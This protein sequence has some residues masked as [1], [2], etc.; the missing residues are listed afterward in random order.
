MESFRESALTRL[1]FADFAAVRRALIGVLSALLLGGSS[2]FVSGSLLDLSFNPT[3]ALHPGYYSAVEFVGLQSATNIVILETYM[4]APSTFVAKVSRLKPQGLLDSSFHAGLVTDS[5][6]ERGEVRSV[7]LQPDGGIIVAG[8]FT[9]FDGVDR[10]NIV[11][12]NADGTLDT[13]FA[14]G[15][16]ILSAEIYNTASQSDGRVLIAGAALQVGGVAKPAGLVRLNPDGTLD[17]SFNPAVNGNIFCLAVQGDGRILVGGEFASVDGTNRLVIARLNGDG[18]LDP[19]FEFVNAAAGARAWQIALQGDGWILLSGQAVGSTNY[20]ETRQLVRL[21]TDGS[22]D[23][24]FDT[25]ASS[26]IIVSQPDGKVLLSGAF[27]AIDGMSRNGVARLMADGTLDLG[28]DPGTGFNASGIGVGAL[29]LQSDGKVL[30]G[31]GFT[32]FDGGPCPTLV[33]LNPGYPSNASILNISNYYG[34]AVSVDEDATNV[35]LTVIRAGNTS[36]NVTVRYRTVDGTAISGTNYLAQS[37]LITFAPGVRTQTIS[38][39]VLDDHQVSGDKT[40]QVYLT[41]ITGGALLGQSSNVAVTVADVDLGLEFAQTNYFADVLQTSVTIPLQV[42]GTHLGP[43]PHSH[44]PISIEISTRDG[45]ARAGRDYDPADGVISNSFFDITLHDDTSAYGDHTVLLTLR[46]PSSNVVLGPLTTAVLT[47]RNDNTA[48]GV[49]VGLNGPI[50]AIA[51]QPDGKVVI[52]GEFTLVDGKSRNHLARLNSDTVLDPTFDPGTGTD[53]NVQALGLQSDGKIIIGGAFTNL[54][55]VYR[56]RIAR[57]NPDGSVDAGFDPGLGWSGGPIWAWANA[58]VTA[59]A[60]QPDGKILTSSLLTNFNGTPRPGLARLNPNG[61][62]DN[63]FAPGLT[64]FGLRAMAALTNGQVVVAGFFPLPA[65]PSH[66]SLAVLNADGSMDTNRAIPSS[67]FSSVFTEIGSLAV[68]PDGDI[69]VTSTASYTGYLPLLKLK[70]DGAV[71]PGFPPQ[72]INGGAGNMTLQSDG[73]IL[74]ASN[75][76]GFLMFYGGLYYTL[77]R[78]NA[79]GS[80]DSG[81]RG[82]RYYSQGT[83]DKTAV[84]PDGS[85]L[86]F[87][88]FTEGNTRLPYYVRRLNPDG[89]DVQDLHFLP[90]VRLPNGQLH[91]ALRGQWAKPYVLQV[92]EYLTNWTTV[93]TNDRPH[94]PIGFI[95]YDAPDFGRRFY[96]VH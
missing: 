86:A 39:P 54:D 22:L 76:A 80:I 53:G 27:A 67:E 94:V 79:D 52:G 78:L 32:S 28:F 26:S 14:T 70:P 90:P 2:A 59:L 12:L 1:A 5:P 85:I 42:M 74:L 47:I 13:N 88:T 29:A 6:A 36:S 57:V 37:G 62:L 7:S 93:A 96:R 45:T 49:E 82:L 35:T 66:A 81:F 10:T 84:L 68:Q 19:T 46:N 40:F 34:N 38:I 91:L 16:S 25:H 64:C 41:N 43:Y 11:R 17:S 56:G 9:H 33:R 51:V 21:N 15:T 77:L 31:G 87:G 23:S 83:V 50:H 18:S 61:S 24:S 48:A 89:S 75:P 71:E 72:S 20:A 4:T 92:S 30:V 69:L 63:G 55:G 8:Y 44:G 58:G 95:D 60:V 65:T 3:N 73:K